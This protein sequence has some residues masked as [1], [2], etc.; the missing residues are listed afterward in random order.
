MSMAG[1][2]SIN[3]V[4]PLSD[5]SWTMPGTLMRNSALISNTIRPLR[6]V[7]SGSWTTSDLCKRRRFRSIISL[8]RF[9]ALRASRRRFCNIGLALSSTSPVGLIAPEM[10]CSK[11]PNSG[12][13][14]EMLVIRGISSWRPSSVRLKRAARS[15]SLMANNSSPRR[16]PPSRACWIDS[17]KS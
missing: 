3:T 1:I 11:S 4:A 16:L 13:L 5:T 6:W 12:M 10:V 14:S 9:W 2:G 8:S 7:I 15:N 17:R